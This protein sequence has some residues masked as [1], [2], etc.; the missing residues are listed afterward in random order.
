M[1]GP[2]PGPG[3]RS[4]Y[5]LNV[6]MLS[7]LLCRIVLKGDPAAKVKVHDIHT[8]ASS[9]SLMQLMD[10][11]DL[12]SA[13]RWK[14]SS[15]F[16]RH[17][18]TLTSRPLQPI[19]VPGGP[20]TSEGNVDDPVPGPSGVSSDWPRLDLSTPFGKFVLLLLFC[21]RGR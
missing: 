11:K 13:M 2:G 19:T 18:L 21:R 3:S 7:K 14:S 12:L 4:I 10:V 5:T 1:P 16:F 6:F 17:Y 15:P 8:F 20:I 9:L